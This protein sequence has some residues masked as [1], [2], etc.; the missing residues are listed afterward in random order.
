M[1]LDVASDKYQ[2]VHLGFEQ[3]TLGDRSV[4]L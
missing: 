1:N 3:S 4:G 2:H